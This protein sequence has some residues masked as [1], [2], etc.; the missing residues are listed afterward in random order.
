MRM[1]LLL[2]RYDF[3]SLIHRRR[4]LGIETNKS[5]GIFQ[6]ST[7]GCRY[8]R[9]INSRN[10]PDDTRNACPRMRLREYGLILYSRTWQTN[11][12][13]TSRV[14]LYEPFVPDI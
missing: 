7:K 5:E 4:S 2:L 11:Y 14:K 9:F 12:D 8:K 1:F 3:R 6:L 13:I 10:L